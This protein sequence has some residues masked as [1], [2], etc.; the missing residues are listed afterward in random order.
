MDYAELVCRSNFSFLKAASHPE[1]LIARAH[2]LGYKAFALADEATVSGS[3][4]AHLAAK[5]LG[6]KLIHGSQ[7]E[8][9]DLP[10]RLTLLVKNREGWRELCRL[11]SLSRQSSDKGQ[12][13][14]RREQLKSLSLANTLALW[15]PQLF[16]P[17]A[18]NNEG[19]LSAGQWLKS[20][21][22]AQL[23]LGYVR[24]LKADDKHWLYQLEELAGLLR[25]PLVAVGD[26]LMHRRKDKPLADM[27]TAI[28]LGEPIAQLGQRLA[29]NAE[30]YLRPRH[31]L[32]QLYPTALMQASLA[33]AEQCH[34]S[35]D[36]LR[37]EY[38]DE[39]VPAGL[40][41]RQWLRHLTED[42]I[43]RRY[44]ESSD[45]QGLPAGVRQQIEHEL[46]L[47]HELNYEPYFLTVY[48]IVAFARSRGILCQGRGSAANSAV[49]Y[50]L[51]ITEVDPAR[52]SMLFERFISKERN[53]PPDIDVDFEHHRREEVIQYIYGKYGRERA[54]L[55]AA[56]VRYRP[57]SA[58]RDSGK[59]LGISSHLVDLAAKGR[60]WWDGKQIC[61]EGL[62]ESLTQ[63][64][65]QSSG[66][67]ELQT[68][69]GNPLA[70]PSDTKLE[71]W[72]ALSSQLMGFPR[73]LSQHVGG[74]VIARYSL[75]DHV[76]TENA[77]MAERS[78]IQWDK[79]DID[80]LGLL[81]VDV[82]A[83]GML[84]AIAHALVFVGQKQ[85]PDKP[86][87]AKPM[88]MQDIPAEDPATYAMISAADTL[89]VFQIES[90][91][92]MSMLPR[93]QPQCF[94]DLV[95]EVAIVRPGPIQGGMV[96][97]YLRRRQGLEPVDYPSPSVK[98]ALERTLGVPI[99]QEQVMQLAILAAGFTA[100]EADQL[101]RAMAAW[102]HRGSLG[103]FQEK[104]VD[105][106]LSRGYS[107][108]FAERVFAQIQ[109]FG[110]YGFPE[111]HAAS[112]AL[113]V[114]V[115]CWLKCHHPDAFLAALLKAQPMGFYAP[116]QLVR[117]ARA[118][119]VE[120]RSVDVQA[121]Q[122]FASL[123]PFNDRWAV[124]LGLHQVAHLTQEAMHRIVQA[125]ATKTFNSVDDLA[126]RAELSRQDLQALAAAGALQS[127]SADRHQAHWLAT[128]HD[129]L[130]GV[131]QDAACEQEL[132]A[133]GLLPVPTEA[134]NL[135]AD[136]ASLGLSLGRHPLALL[137]KELKE[138]FQSRPAIELQKLGH[139]QLA[140]ASGLVTHRQRP[141]TAKGVVFITLEDETGSINLIIWPDVLKIYKQAV[142]H[143]QLLT[144]YGRWQ[145]DQTIAT[146]A[147]GQVMNLV[148]L[149]IED[150]T[151]LLAQRLGEMASSSRDF[152]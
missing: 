10:G 67:K 24:H 87:G 110:E 113:L 36:E 14:L 44:P 13:S 49:C 107:R 48:D 106:M 139:Q 128:G 5:S 144:A 21:W 140:R 43:R 145:R 148:A 108:D 52:M 79:D 101:R 11:I 53:E 94:Y 32:A 111:S 54:A 35:L 133:A 28:R 68:T 93:L 7:F 143:G 18:L 69:T 70:I 65:I 98:Q 86:L 81:K 105:G 74:F 73:H 29:V 121:S 149:R 58:L 47:I 127:L 56:L 147:P 31:R 118:H 122:V 15:S 72:A 88:A 104:L 130:P 96:H 23:A 132:P 20:L 4:R 125:R 116:A 89:G 19:L 12:Y 135:I 63:G 124:R 6:L 39:I 8:L 92:Q 22:G 27:L 120:V 34:F 115:S 80:A 102:R 100:G 112:F 82:L 109:G 55:A 84:S 117:D 141:G 99:F 9:T 152:H 137:R 78:V 129:Q 75:H 57:R 97:P 26:V 76:P 71:Q 30:Q 45:A 60:S 77:S 46:E 136:Y 134:Q 2:A 41:P 123:E 3:V 17:Q 91:A 51:G 66:N 142:L 85:H 38:P 114:Y 33:L 103:P 42:G 64:L 83:L 131:L 146:D 40:T 50:C 25:L 61:A 119:G 16:R 90:R 37:Y 138:R 95:I 1:D 150:H 59:A 62:R 126:M 151:P